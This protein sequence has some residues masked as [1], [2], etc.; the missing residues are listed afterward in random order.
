MDERV[1]RESP[2]LR[3][4]AALADDPRRERI[5]VSDVFSAGGPHGAVVALVLVFALPNVIPAPPGT[6]AVL[7]LPLLLLTLEWMLGRAAWLP[8][9]IARR[10]IARHDFAAL[11]ARATPWIV[12]TRR[13]LAPRLD[14]LL[15]PLAVHLAAA[16]CVVL[17]LLI[18]LPIPLGNML[19][20]WAISIIAV[21]VIGRDGAWVLAGSATGFASI[22]LV[23]SVVVALAQAAL[24]ALHQWLG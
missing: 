2:F 18:M 17:A 9:F 4:L 14:L 13:W 20:A 3:H 11:L 22:A 23:W 12:R 6:S 7:G 21:G 10:S 15:T 5:S 24:A 1:T 8:T 19:P 16:L